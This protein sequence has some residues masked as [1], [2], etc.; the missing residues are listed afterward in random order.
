MRELRTGEQVNE[1]EGMWLKRGT[2]TSLLYFPKFLSNLIYGL[3]VWTCTLS[4]FTWT[5]PEHEFSLWPPGVSNQTGV[6]EAGDSS[7]SVRESVWWSDMMPSVVC[8]LSVCLLTLHTGE[9][10]DLISMHIQ[11]LTAHHVKP[12]VFAAEFSQK[13]SNSSDRNSSAADPGPGTISM[14]LSPLTWCF[15][16][17][18]EL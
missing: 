17:K 11:C 15:I 10:Q 13:P 9:K 6:T 12:F 1:E 18:S 7:K 14:F 16:W 2:E 4:G 8:L 3:R 5:R